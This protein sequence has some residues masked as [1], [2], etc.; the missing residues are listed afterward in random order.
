MLII[1]TAIATGEDAT[2]LVDFDLLM[3]APHFIGDGTSL[4]QSTHELLCIVTSSKS[5]AELIEE[6]GQAK[7]WV[8]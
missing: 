4:H 5:D 2:G 3:C 1:S 8:S 7:D 6:L